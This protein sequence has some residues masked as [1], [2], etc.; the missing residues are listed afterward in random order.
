MSAV[1][2]ID[3]GMG[4][5]HSV[6]RALEHVGAEPAL[7]ENPDDVRAAELLVLPGVGAFRDGMA[8]L[9]R[10]GLVEALRAY[11][12]TG[13]PLLGICLGM[14]MLF[15]ESEEFGRH[16]GL[17]LLKGAVRAIP[18][19]GADG[20]PHKIPHVGWRAVQ[21]AW[22]GAWN[23]TL[24]AETP[25]GAEFYFVHSYTAM[26]VLR[27]DRLADADYDGCTIS[28][29]VRRGNVYGFQFHPEKS[30]PAGL[31]LLERFVRT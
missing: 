15:E 28:A 16:E 6:C 19:Q 21:P 13:Q 10:R 11:A 25:H 12:K 26:P 24:M 17:G 3:Y 23:D 22:E 1:T 5:L 20:K 29:A 31:A 8:E 7:T 30:G 2:V 18:K 14:Q 27:E 9:G 4:N